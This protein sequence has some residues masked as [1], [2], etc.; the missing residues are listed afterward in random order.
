MALE[1]SLANTNSRPLATA[2]TLS[3]EIPGGAFSSSSLSRSEKFPGGAL[4][5]TSAVPPCGIFTGVAH[6]QARRTIDGDGEFLRRHDMPVD[7]CLHRV[8][9]GHGD[10]RDRFPGDQSAPFNGQGNGIFQGL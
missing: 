8:L 9:R 2:E 7:E 4:R 3:N 6:N 10:V 5:R 1:A